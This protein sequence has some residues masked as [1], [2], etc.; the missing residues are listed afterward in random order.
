MVLFVQGEQA[1]VGNLRVF[2]DADLLLSFKQKK[3]LEGGRRVHLLCLSASTA[4]DQPE[5]LP[6]KQDDDFRL[7]L[8]CLMAVAIYNVAYTAICWTLLLSRF[9]FCYILL[10]NPVETRYIQMILLPS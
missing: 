8:R 2:C 7:L 3:R 4:D 6:P 5:P 10:F 1:G 9:L